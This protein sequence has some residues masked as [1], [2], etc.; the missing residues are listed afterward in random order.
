[1]RHL[2]RRPAEPRCDAPLGG[3]FAR[4]FVVA[5]IR[6]APVV[7]SASRPGEHRAHDRPRPC[8]GLGALIGPEYP[9]AL[10]VIGLISALAAACRGAR[11]RRAGGARRRY[12]RRS[13]SVG[14]GRRARTATAGSRLVAAIGR[15]RRTGPGARLRSWSSQPPEPTQ[16]GV[17][18]PRDQENHVHR[19]GRAAVLCIAL[20]RWPPAPSAPTSRGR[21][22][23]H[24]RGGLPRRAG[25]HRAEERARVLRLPREGEPAEGLEETLEA[26]VTFGTR[27]ARSRSARASASRAP[28]SRSSSRPPPVRTRSGSSA[29]SRAS[30]STSRSPRARTPSAR[31][32]TPPGA[33]S[34]SVPGRGRR[35]PDAEAGAH[36]A[37]TPRSRSYGRSGLL[38]AS[39]P[40]A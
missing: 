23:T 17:A 30:R 31:S 12:R 11:R 1:M 29:R 27:R 9:L 20:S 18:R 34:R 25:I 37:T 2:R 21:S 13:A 39:L 32:R 35:L 7:A 22:T 24:V 4:R 38:A 28:T 3:P 36:A 5:W 19:L 26:E 14:S 8:P 15:P 10:P 16:S 6:L 40:S 33:S